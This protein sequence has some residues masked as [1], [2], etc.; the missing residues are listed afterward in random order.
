ML[1]KNSSF[2]F[3]KRSFPSLIFIL[4]SALYLTFLVNLQTLETAM[5]RVFIF[6]YFVVMG[7]LACFLKGKYAEGK[8][9]P[10]QSRIAAALLAALLVGAGWNTF[11]PHVRFPLEGS[12]MYALWEKLLYTLGAWCVVFYFA[13]LA[14]LFWSK[15]IRFRD[16]AGDRAL[17][18]TLAEALIAWTLMHLSGFSSRFFDTPCPNP[19]LYGL[20]HF[21]FLFVMIYPCN[22]FYENRNCSSARRAF[23]ITTVFFA[24]A[25]M[26]LLA[27]WPGNYTW[28]DIWIFQEA[29]HYNLSPWQHFFSGL[30][31]VL[32][33]QTLPISCGVILIQIYLAALIIGYSV[34]QLSED[35]S[36]TKRPFLC[37]LLLLV[38]LFPPIL[39]WLFSGFRIALYSFLETLLLTK[40]ILI[41]QRRER[42][43]LI[44]CLKIVLLTILVA[45][46]RSEG[47]Y[48]V[49]VIA[50]FFFLFRKDILSRRKAAV[51]FVL[52]AVSVIGIG[53]ANSAMIGSSNY[54]I[55][56]T[57]YPA[58]ELIR[59]ADPSEDCSEL[60]SISRV[61]DVDA[62]MEQS[63]ASAESLYWSN[64]LVKNGYS[65]EDYSAYTSGFVRLCLR[66]PL[67][68]ANALWR[69]FLDSSGV[70]V[71]NG[72]TAQ[73][74]SI[75]SGSAL[76]EGSAGDGWA[77]LNVPLKSPI[78]M[79]LRNQVMLWLGCIRND[80][81]VTPAYYFFWN[82]WIPIF[83][84]AAGLAVSI[85]RK[86]S[87]MILVMV[88]VFCRI[89]LVAAASSSAYIMYYLPAYLQMYFFGIVC[90]VAPARRSFSDP[91][92]TEE[93]AL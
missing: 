88:T 7:V 22:R 92:L 40:L 12:H 85:V 31:H 79:S 2:S 33:M 15:H 56:A 21:I 37:I 38:T 66:H 78:N 36:R 62:V 86:D 69:N 81:T 65:E 24:V 47:I 5:Q 76:Y 52:I 19:L 80:G 44:D 93:K 90:L 75:V 67:T 83:L 64:A 17:S 35:F 89:P 39:T 60:D 74:R 32:C 4:F 18:N 23:V 82:L 46:W 50:L 30:F 10:L 34:S 9:F 26:L 29:Q 41:Y 48:Y 43:S 1:M 8:P 13:Q 28:D 71:T 27:A 25:F 73:R 57:M 72:Y 87:V 51:C 42:M 59:S 61:I 16:S 14:L 77:S 84:A 11:L 70:I 6:C 53:K 54:S 55:T 45:S 49:A 20:L 63:D 3:F 58:V 68:V 91:E